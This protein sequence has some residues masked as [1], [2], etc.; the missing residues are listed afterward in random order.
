MRVLAVTVTMFV[1]ITARPA[2]ADDWPRWTGNTLMQKCHAGDDALCRGYVMGFADSIVLHNDFDLNEPEPILCIPSH[3][4]GKQ[5]WNLVRQY[6]DEKPEWRDRPADA[7]VS[8]VL[9]ETFP[10]LAQ[11]A[12]SAH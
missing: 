10:C 11:R 7:L 4:D 6:L 5:L 1:L 2:K 3:M 12:P 8:E 9:L